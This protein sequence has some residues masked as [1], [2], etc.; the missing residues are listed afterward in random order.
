[1]ICLGRCSFFL[2]ISRA[3]GTQ[4]QVSDQ[5]AQRAQPCPSLHNPTQTHSSS[6]HFYAIPALPQA[7][8][9][10]S[11]WSAGAS[12]LSAHFPPQHSVTAVLEAEPQ[13][14]G[15]L[16]GEALL[17]HLHPAPLQL[18]DIGAKI[19]RQSG[20]KKKV[21]PSP[22]RKV[23]LML[24]MACWGNPFS[25]KYNQHLTPEPTWGRQLC[26]ATKG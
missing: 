6:C 2:Q 3:M 26:P 1:M 21:Q 16:L 4:S 18:S 24:D 23:T 5:R 13:G 17:L 20:K 14:R 7:L 19:Y 12:P 10:I 25:P 8:G 15:L 11:S 9:T 22:G